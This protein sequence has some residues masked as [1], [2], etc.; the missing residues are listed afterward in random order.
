MTASAPGLVCTDGANSLWRSVLGALSHRLSPAT[1]DSLSQSTRCLG[2]ASGSL[3]LAV[4]RG[5]LESWIR[6][7]HV[8]AIESS[9]S[10]LT[11]AAVALA[12]IPVEDVRT[13]SGDPS[14]SFESFI[15]SPSNSAALSRARRFAGDGIADGGGL[16]ISG[17]PGSGKTH[18]LRA[19]ATRRE[20]LEPKSAVLYRRADQLSLYLVG[21]ILTGDLSSF[22][23]HL[24]ASAA[25]LLD[26][27]H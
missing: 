1:R 8:G 20:G 7:G 24:I 13:L 12:L 10:S 5:E 6:A 25:L 3:R 2:Q 11:D 26:D 23:E 22:R 17:G 9:L 4:N 19:I 27:L 21:A 18:L 16:A 15:A 14:S